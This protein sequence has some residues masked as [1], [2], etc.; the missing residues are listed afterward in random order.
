MFHLLHIF[1]WLTKIDDFKFEYTPRDSSCLPKEYTAAEGET[2][3][4]LDGYKH[5]G[6]DEKVEVQKHIDAAMDQIN[7][8]LKN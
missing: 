3:F 8:E 7:N 1:S 2:C 5:A 6:V 4:F